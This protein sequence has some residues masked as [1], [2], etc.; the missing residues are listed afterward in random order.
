[1]HTNVTLTGLWSGEHDGVYFEISFSSRLRVRNVK[2]AVTK[3]IYL[4][5]SYKN[6][7]EQYRRKR[8]G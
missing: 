8:C 6:K 3:L 4:R 2:T 7:T 1:M 5:C